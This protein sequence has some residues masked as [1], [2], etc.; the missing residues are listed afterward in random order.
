MKD[1]HWYHNVNQALAKWK[2]KLESSKIVA[3]CEETICDAY[4][5]ADFIDDDFRQSETARINLISNTHKQHHY[6]L[7]IHPHN[8]SVSD[9]FQCSYPS[10]II[11][12]SMSDWLYEIYEEQGPMCPPQ[13]FI[14]TCKES[15]TMDNF[16][17][18]QILV[19]DGFVYEITA[20]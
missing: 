17:M 4:T 12:D 1:E 13:H 18:E 11:G 14:S 2:H 6:V 19:E 20:V 3:N 8:K 9:G 15:L 7:T 10:I 16:E 5:H